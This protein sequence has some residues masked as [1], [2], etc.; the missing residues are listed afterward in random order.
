MLLDGVVQTSQL[1][2]TAVFNPLYT[3]KI[4]RDY[5]IHEKISNDFHVKRKFDR[6]CFTVLRSSEIVKEGYL[7]E[8]RV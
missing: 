1:F 4:A 3:I 7:N 5:V 2:P 8:K 6:P